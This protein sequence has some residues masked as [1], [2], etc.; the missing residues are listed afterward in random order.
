MFWV[1]LRE[2]CQFSLSIQKLENTCI[3]DYRS[4]CDDDSLPFN[5]NS[6]IIETDSVLHFWQI[7]FLTPV[8]VLISKID[9]LGPYFYCRGSLLGPYFIK[10]GSLFLSSEV[11]KSFNISAMSQVNQSA[12]SQV[13]QIFTIYHIFLQYTIQ[14]VTSG[15]IFLP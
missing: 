3:I 1:N 2:E 11:P 9:D 6:K 15:R 14:I 7:H 4:V 13:N 5:I 12:M 8:Y 10:V